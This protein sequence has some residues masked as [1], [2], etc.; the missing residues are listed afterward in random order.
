MIPS[1]IF[2]VCLPLENIIRLVPLPKSSTNLNGHLKYPYNSYIFL[3][4][5]DGAGEILN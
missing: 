1:S 2:T 5:I 3:D 4:L